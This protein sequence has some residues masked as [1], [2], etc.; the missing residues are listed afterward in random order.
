MVSCIQNC[1]ISPCEVTDLIVSKDGRRYTLAPTYAHPH[2]DENNPGNRYQVI[3]SW[4]KEKAAAVVLET[5]TS[6]QCEGA[7]P[8]LQVLGLR[9]TTETLPPGK[10]TYKVPCP[11]PPKELEDGKFPFWFFL[12][13]LLFPWKATAA[14]YD[15]STHCCAVHRKLRAVVE[16]YPQVAWKGSLKVEFG[17]RSSPP[18]GKGKK[19]DCRPDV[20][21]ANKDIMVQYGNKEYHLAFDPV[22]LGAQAIQEILNKTSG[23][24]DV[25]ALVYLYFFLLYKAG[26]LWQVYQY[27]KVGLPDVE[28]INPLSAVKCE[29]TWPSLTL[30]GEVENVELPGDYRV[31][32]KGKIELALTIFEFDIKLD[33]FELL[34]ALYC[35][36]LAMLKDKARSVSVGKNVRFGVNLEVLLSGKMKISGGAEVTASQGSAVKTNGSVSAFG[37]LTLQGEPSVQGEWL[38][39]C[40]GAAGA[41]VLLA[42][43]KDSATPS[44]LTGKVP[45]ESPKEEG[46]LADFGKGRI[47]FNGLAFYYAVYSYVKTIDAKTKD[48][49]E[50]NPAERG[51]KTN[52]NTQLEEIKK[53]EVTQHAVL[54]EPFTWVPGADLEPDTFPEHWLNFQAG[55]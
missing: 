46:K 8:S 24:K 23:S 11:K 49:D 52:Q 30:S 27:A 19:T 44:G 50:N 16:A 48:Q 43:K 5:H 20:K 42:S 31:G 41:F 47:E 6:C 1:N 13:E 38:N 9:G 45:I 40:S 36:P 15:V 3:S 7:R 29:L 34:A 21:V 55:A 28:P 54:W 2:P 33:I 22:N 53:L 51:K 4:E 39:V 35:K 32:T 17:A 18:E 37:G 12:K 25:D 26:F 10:E 14:S